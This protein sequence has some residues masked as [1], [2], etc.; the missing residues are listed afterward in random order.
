MPLAN[1][2]EQGK[3]SIAQRPLAHIKLANYTEIIL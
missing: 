1:P 2:P 3:A